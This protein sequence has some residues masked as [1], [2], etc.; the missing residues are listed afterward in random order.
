MVDGYGGRVGQSPVAY[1]CWLSIING[2]IFLLY[3]RIVS[4]RILPNLLSEA[5]GIF[6]VGGGAS[7]AA[8]AMVMWAFSKAPIAVVMAMRETSIL[9][10]VLIGFFFLKEEITLPKIFGSLITVFGIVLLRAS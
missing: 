1:Y 8:Y 3:S 10:A 4:S 9:F 2:L 5:K 6:F 7:L